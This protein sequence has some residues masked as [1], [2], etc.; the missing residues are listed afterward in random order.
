[1]MVFQMAGC[2]DQKMDFCWDK[3]MEKKRANHLDWWRGSCWGL[4]MAGY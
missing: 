2:W 4:M 1:M 3:L